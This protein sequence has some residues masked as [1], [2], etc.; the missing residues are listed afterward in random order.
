VKTIVVPAPHHVLGSEPFAVVSSYNGKSEAQIKA[1]VLAAL[2]KDYA[3]GGLASLKQ[4]ELVEF[5]LNQT[6]KVIKSEV[7]E[8]VEKYIARLECKVA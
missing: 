2:G 8:A 7:Q 3:L 4:L 1:G 5:P 6:H